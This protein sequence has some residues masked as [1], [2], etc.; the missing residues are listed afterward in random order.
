M[1]G[2]ME[3]QSGIVNL[4]QRK[5]IGRRL[6]MTLAD[7]QTIKLWQSFMPARKQIENSVTND[8]YSMQVYPRSFDFTVVNPHTEFDKWAAVEVADF[9]IVPDEMETFVLKG[10]LYAVFNY[11]G[12][13]TDPRIFRYIFETWLPDSKEYTLDHR[14]HFELLGEKYKNNDPGSEEEI[15]I[16]IRLKN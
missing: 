3:V 1:T 16:P 9:D 10:G 14:P 7:D 8:L 13:S 12:L 5:L 4:N 6:K 2:Q 15:W 11:R